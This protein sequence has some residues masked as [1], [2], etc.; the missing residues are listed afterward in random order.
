MQ[1]L[2]DMTLWDAAKTVA[3]LVAVLTVTHLFSSAASLALA[4]LPLAATLASA[5]IV[6]PFWL[7]ILFCPNRWD[8]WRPCWSLSVGE[9]RL[10]LTIA[11][12]LAVI[13]SLFLAAALHRAAAEEVARAS[14][15]D[16]LPALTNG[17]L[18]RADLLTDLAGYWVGLSLVGLLVLAILVGAYWAALF[19][20]RMR[21]ALRRAPLP[22]SIAKDTLIIVGDRH[23]GLD[24][25]EAGP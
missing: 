10:K 20:R 24:R 11:G 2:P 14:S 19:T 6:L 9:W 22:R 5:A 13:G 21:R 3:L 16:A 4:D 7:T 18:A 15:G 8:G 25:R 23:A 12:I 1:K 17:L